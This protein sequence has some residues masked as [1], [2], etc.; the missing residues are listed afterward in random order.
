MN[1]QT[2]ADQFYGMPEFSPARLL[3]KMYKDLIGG[4]PPPLGILFF[5]GQFA[6]VNWEQFHSKL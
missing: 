2:E 6:E 1:S 4:L 3:G 5:S